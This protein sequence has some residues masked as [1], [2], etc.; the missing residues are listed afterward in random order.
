M[1]PWLRNQLLALVH[2]LLLRPGL[3]ALGHPAVAH[4]PLLEAP[5]VATAVAVVAPLVGGGLVL[6]PLP[7]LS[8][9]PPGPDLRCGGKD[10]VWEQNLVE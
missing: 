9:R 7:G 1:L 2:H 10:L 4:C 8:P 5:V 3:D 6:L